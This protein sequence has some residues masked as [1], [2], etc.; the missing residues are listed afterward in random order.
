MKTSRFCKLLRNV[1][2]DVTSGL[3][4][5]LHDVISL[6]DVRSF[7]KR[8][9]SIVWVRSN[10]IRMSVDAVAYFGHARVFKIFSL[11]LSKTMCMKWICFRVNG[12][13]LI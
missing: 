3:K 6:P 1:I 7:D 11:Y 9:S 10:I 13:H 12:C 4:V 8:I 5:L 2:K